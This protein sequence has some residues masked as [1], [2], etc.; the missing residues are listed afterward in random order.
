MMDSHTKRRAGRVC[1]VAVFT[2]LL[3]LFLSVNFDFYYDLNDDTMIKDILSGAYTGKP[4]GF[5]IQMLY[6]LG[7]F[8]ALFYRAIPTVAWYGLFCA[9]ASLE[10]LHWLHCVLCALCAALEQN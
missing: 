6:P 4:N 8:I 2:L 7:W 5:C 9:Y 10:C 3:V 1:V